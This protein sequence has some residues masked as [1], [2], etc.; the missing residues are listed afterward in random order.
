VPSSGKFHWNTEPSRESERPYAHG[1][2]RNLVDWRFLRESESDAGREREDVGGARGAF[3]LQALVA[4]HAAIGGVIGVTFLEHDLHA[5]D[6]AVAFVNQGVVVGD[7]VGDWDTVG[8]VGAGAVDK[9]GDELLVLRQGRRS[10]SDSGNK[11]RERAPNMIS[12]H[13]LLP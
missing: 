12:I 11:S 13:R 7:A 10:E 8:G 1:D 4:F 2:E 9:L 5:V 3:A 6:A